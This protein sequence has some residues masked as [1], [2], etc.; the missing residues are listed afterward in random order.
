M[1]ITMEFHSIL[2]LHCFAV[3]RITLIVLW[4]VL[5]LLLCGQPDVRLEEVYSHEARPHAHPDLTDN[6]VNNLILNRV[7]PRGGG[8]GGGGGGVERF[9][10]CG[11][12][13]G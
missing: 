9:K 6:R 5:N 13:G 12:G 2:V 8:G 10:V 11:R 4:V 7:P 3:F 1:T